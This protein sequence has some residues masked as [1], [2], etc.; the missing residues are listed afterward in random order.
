MAFSVS[1]ERHWQ[2]RV[3]EIAKV[4]KRPQWDSNPRP[5][6]CQSRALTS[7][8]QRHLSIKRHQLPRYLDLLL[9]MLLMPIFVHEMMGV[10]PCKYVYKAAVYIIL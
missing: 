9:N 3:K 8:P 5:L 6:D 1:S 2:S 7:E 4:S 10:I